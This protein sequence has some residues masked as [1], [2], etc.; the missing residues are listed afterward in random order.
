MWLP[1]FAC[2]ICRGPI[3]TAGERCVCRACAASFTPS[4]GLFR[5]A[6]ESR[7]AAA[8][9]FLTQYA[10]VRNADGHGHQSQQAYRAL[11]DVPRNHPNAGEWAI[12]RESFRTICRS[13]ALCTARGRR[14]LDIGAGN[15]WLSNRLAEMGHDAVPVDLRDDA[16]DGLL[17]CRASTHALALVQADFDALPFAP[18]QFHAV[19]FNAALHYSPNPEATLTE[20][21]RMLTRDGV[22]LVADSP[23][24]EDA[25]AGAA[26]LAGQRSAMRAGGIAEP[27]TTGVG[28]LTFEVLARIT[29]SMGRRGSFVPSQGPLRWRI[30]RALGGYRLGR[31]PAAFGVWVIQ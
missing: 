3:Q 18:S 13:A 19:V 7:I 27:F 4:Q 24:F 8:A 31:P 1:T 6:P 20:A 2:P 14:I 29:A 16:D 10:A 15:G 17:A 21:S 28:F 12:R 30:R 25:D 26:M 23:M 9:A 11:P 5:F 22:L